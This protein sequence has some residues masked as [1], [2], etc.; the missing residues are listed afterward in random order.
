MNLNNNDSDVWDAML[1]LK[2]EYVK[3]GIPY[4]AIKIVKEETLKNEKTGEELKIRKVF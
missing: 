4:K 2:S 3:Q 1:K